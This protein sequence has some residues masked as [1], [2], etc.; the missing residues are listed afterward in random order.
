[1]VDLT[2]KIHIRVDSSEVTDLLDRLLDRLNKLGEL[3]PGGVP[4][5]FKGIVTL[6]TDHGAAGAGELVMRLK[7][8]DSFLRFASAVFAGNFD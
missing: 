7:P 8:T 1:M 4:D 6:E 3:P 2:Q 5:S